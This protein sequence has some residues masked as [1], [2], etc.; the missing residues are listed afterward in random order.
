MADTLAL[1]GARLID[2]RG[3]DPIDS[4]TVIVADGRI[5]RAQ[6]SH[7]ARVPRGARHV[8]LTGLTLLPGLIDCHVHL[9]AEL[10]P[11]QEEHS[12]RLSER[13]YRGIPYAKATLDAG[14]TTA[15]DAGMTPAGMRIAIDDGIFP[16]PR[17]KVAVNIVTQTGGH[18]DWQL[19]SGLDPGWITSDLPAGISDSP[20]EMRKVVRTMIRA[21]ADW[22]KI[23]STGGV[24]SPLDPPD[25]PQFT[26]E[27]IAVAV[28][29]AKAARLGGVMSHAIGAQGIKNAV[30]A[31]VRSIEHGY[32]IDEEAI[33]LMV[34]SG[35]WLVPT[36]HALVSVRERAEATPG[37][38]APWAMAK[39]DGVTV[40]QR[41]T[42][43]EAIRRG[44]KVAMGTDC[45]VGHHGTNAR[46]LGL[47]VAAGMSPMAAIESAT[48]VAAQLLGLENEI[49]TIEAGKAGDLIAVAADPLTDPNAIADPMTVRLVIKGGV[50]A[51]DLDGRAS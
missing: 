33:D 10:R 23:C 7:Q 8:D 45:G 11:V 14:I 47:L 50:V 34:R 31:G 37:S 16:G 26:V 22:I 2:G 38:I 39:L 49:G 48:R 41:E 28:A 12:E 3:G 9:L 36:L 43:P 17:L 4:A 20:D 21:G 19:A 1:E 46:E 44:V 51:K 27:E 29:E 13:L 42:L 6:P 35:T 30:H 32:M 5:A 24:L 40:A 25:T 18:G 15:R